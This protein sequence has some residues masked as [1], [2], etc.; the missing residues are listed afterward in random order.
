MKAEFALS[1]SLINLVCGFISSMSGGRPPIKTFLEWHLEKE[2]AQKSSFKNFP[3]IDQI[4]KKRSLIQ[5]TS[6]KIDIN[7]KI[8][9]KP[10][11][12][13]F[14]ALPTSWEI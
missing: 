7:D 2:L 8:P 13:I 14:T 3:K 9:T 10:F 11:L 6:S 1:Y 12:N 5:V 4:S